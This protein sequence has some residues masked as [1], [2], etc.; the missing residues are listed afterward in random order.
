M[1]QNMVYSHISANVVVSWDVMFYRLLGSR[2]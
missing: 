1:P 2:D